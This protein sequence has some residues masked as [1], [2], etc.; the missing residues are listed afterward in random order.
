MRGEFVGFYID[1]HL[2]LKSVWM[3]VEI[4]GLKT[5]RTAPKYAKISYNFLTVSTIWV[6][7]LTKRIW[8]PKNNLRISKWVVCCFSQIWGFP[9]KR[10][11]HKLWLLDVHRPAIVL[12]QS[13]HFL[14][15]PPKPAP[16]GLPLPP[17]VAGCA[18]ARPS[19]YSPTLVV[20]LRRRQTN[21]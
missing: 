12:L 2:F 10:L 21:Q 3:W 6:V 11:T 4:L 5:V 17:P 14:L 15:Q 1:I 16:A 13:L 20:I 8:A 18:A 7:M 9:K 19:L